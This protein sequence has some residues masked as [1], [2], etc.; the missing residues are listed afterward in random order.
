MN[1]QEK[2]LDVLEDMKEFPKKY[3]K[4][5]IHDSHATICPQNGGGMRVSKAF[6][7]E[8]Q[9]GR[10]INTYQFDASEPAEDQ[11]FILAARKNKFITYVS[12]GD[13]FEQFGYIPCQSKAEDQ[14]VDHLFCGLFLTEHLT[15]LLAGGS[16]YQEIL[17][18]EILHEEDQ[19]DV[20]EVLRL[21][22]KSIPQQEVDYVQEEQETFEIN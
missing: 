14:K 4:F 8:F 13:E 5:Y 7:A 9:D 21:L 19:P 11:T 15:V 12:S 6:L 2:I 1:N 10:L 16:A 3:F 17:Y 20:L 22:A 18:R